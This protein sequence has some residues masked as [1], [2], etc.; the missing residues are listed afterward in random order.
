MKSRL[1]I[2]LLCAAVFFAAS[3][4]AECAYFE[5]H[6]DH[7]WINGEKTATCEEAGESFRDC[8]TCGLH[9]QLGTTAATGHSWI[10]GSTAPDCTNAGEKYRDCSICG[11]H[12][13]IETIAA[14]GHSWTESSTAAGCETAG[15]TA[16]DCSVC[17][18]HE[19]VVI[20]A[21]GHDWVECTTDATCE[22]AGEVY[23]ECSR[24][25]ARQTVQTIEANGHDWVDKEL[26]SSADCENDGSMNKCCSICGEERIFILP[27]EGHSYGEWETIEKAT[28]SSKGEKRKTCYNCGYEITEEIKRTAHDYG[29]WE[30]SIEATDNSMGLRSHKCS[31]CGASAEEWFYPDGTLYRG[32]YKNDEVLEMQEKLIY[33]GFLND[34]ADGIFGKKTEQAVKDF[35]IAAELE[36][37]GVAYPET[38][39]AIDEAVKTAEVKAAAEDDAEEK[40]IPDSCIYSADG[41][42]IA[43]TVHCLAHRELIAESE[44]IYADSDDKSAA[45]EE[46]RF[47]WQNELGILYAD[48][49]ESANETEK[50]YIEA[51]QTDFIS[52]LM[53]MEVL[54]EQ[55]YADEPDTVQV[56]AIDLLREQCAIV[57]SMAE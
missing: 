3:A 41:L 38:L 56:L 24:C 12:E 33:L 29:E 46:I 39:S 26:I 53:S 20:E 30:I 7:D 43:E 42:N 49:I 32:M 2:I 35:Q 4:Y 40:D 19:A 8:S 22:A 13:V 57:C 36:E 9:E 18:A 50:P 47:I 6:G 45:L 17:G 14:A 25:A 37:T 15:E 27:A 55:V 54:W 1:L 5:E 34:T 10:E 23:Q 16:K 31:D 21:L 52:Y 51:A 44:A 11:K 28:C 48:W